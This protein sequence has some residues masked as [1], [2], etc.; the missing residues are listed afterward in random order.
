MKYQSLGTRLLGY[1]SPNTNTTI[2][3]VDVKLD[4]IVLTT[5]EPKVDATLLGVLEKNKKEIFKY[6]NK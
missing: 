3:L 1:L 4:K 6:Y 5:N 2:T